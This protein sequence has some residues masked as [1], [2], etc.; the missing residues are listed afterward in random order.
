ME[1][2]K[3]SARPT[4]HGGNTTWR[5]KGE[6]LHPS[7]DVP[8]AFRTCSYCGSI[9]PEDLLQALKAGA[10]LGG[11]DWKYGWPHK[12]YVEKIPNPN[13]GQ[14]VSRTSMSI[15][16]AEPTAEERASMERWGKKPGSEVRVKQTG[17][18]SHDGKPQYSLAVFEPDGPTTH[19]KWYNEHLKDLSPEAFDELVP[20]LEQHTGIKF[21]RDE[22]GIKYSAPYRGY[23]R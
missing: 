17:F 6:K 21:E 15:R 5:P 11:A 13:E 14:L 12:F 4:C 22:N 18:S 16:S 7:H 10:T 9:H 3:W 20:L 2:N 8:M 23:Q 1:A 19:S